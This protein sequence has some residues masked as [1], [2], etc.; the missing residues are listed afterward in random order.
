V[1]KLIVDR[2]VLITG[3]A[4]GLGLATVRALDQG[5]A[6]IAVFDRDARALEALSRELPHALLRLVELTD[7]KAVDAA[8]EDLFASFGSINTLINN[9]GI[10]RSAPLIDVLQ[11]QTRNQRMAVWD[12]VIASNLSAIFGLTMCVAERM[13][14]H[15]INGVIVNVS[16]IAA[17]GNPGQSAY[18]AAKAGVEALTRTWAKELGPLGIRANCVSPGFIDTP[19]THAALGTERVS[20]LEGEVPLRRL[21]AASEVAMAIMHLIENDYANGAVLRVDG[22]L[23]I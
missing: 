1:N 16:S 4:S 2:S 13:L 15:R 22:G 19:S 12:D 10:I 18:S 8:V 9:A 14:K 6:R 23:V 3:G 11:R 7:L 20:M 5:G 21:G 17:S